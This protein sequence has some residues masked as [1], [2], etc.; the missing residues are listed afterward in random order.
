MLRGY[1]VLGSTSSDR[2]SQQ[3]IVDQFMVGKIY[4]CW[5]DPAN[6]TQAV[7][8]R[9]FDWFI[10]IIPGVFFLVGGIFF[11]VGLVIVIQTRN[12]MNT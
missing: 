9:Q 2:A 1:D 11:V 7:L 10:F 3:A 6:P 12:K 8:T 5:Y 4:P